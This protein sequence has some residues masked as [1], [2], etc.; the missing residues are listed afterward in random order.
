[1]MAMIDGDGDDGDDDDDVVNEVMKVMM[2]VMMMMVSMI[3]VKVSSDE[4]DDGGGGCADL[5]CDRWR[6]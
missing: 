3:E 5:S 1:M 4:C 2:M 6:R